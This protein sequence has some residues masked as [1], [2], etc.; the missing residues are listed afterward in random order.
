MAS[1]IKDKFSDGAGGTS[2]AAF[3]ITI[4][5]LASST[6]FVGRQTTMVDNSTTRFGLVHIF[7]K[8]TLGTS[9]TS[10]KAVYVFAI[11]GDK[12]GTAHRSDAAG[13][14]DA[15]LTR[16]NAPFICLARSSASAATGDVVQCEE[17]L[18]N[19]GPEFG[20]MIY[21]DTGVALNSTGTNSWLRWV[22]NN[23]E[24]Q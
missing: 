18:V 10:N 5:S 6:T 3:T 8:F 21:Q 12:N 2:S 19:P 16:L 22:G 4:A 1:E 23:P 13:A 9:P 24:A 11:R 14:S 15:A 7:G 17:F 20:A